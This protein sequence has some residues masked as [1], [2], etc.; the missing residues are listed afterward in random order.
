METTPAVGVG[1][2]RIGGRAANLPWGWPSGRSVLLLYAVAFSLIVSMGAWL[3]VGPEAAQAAKP[4]SSLGLRAEYDVAAN[5]NW[6]Q[7]KMTVTS[8]AHIRNTRDNNVGKLAFNLLPL[9]LGHID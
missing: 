3:V 1:A 5:I 8:V 4:V 2:G 6:Q 9:K 7:G